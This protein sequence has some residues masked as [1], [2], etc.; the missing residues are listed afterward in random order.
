MI[1][2][3]NIISGMINQNKENDIFYFVQIIK[4]RKDNPDMI[5]GESE[6][7]NFFIS[8]AKDLKGLESEIIKLCDMHN[9]RAYITLNKK[10][11]EKVAK[12]TVRR[13]AET[14]ESGNYNIRGIYNSCCSKQSVKK[15][16]VW[17]LDI[18]GEY[19]FNDIAIDLLKNNSSII[20]SL[21]TKNGIHMIVKPFN[22]DEFVK[23][24]P[25]LIHK[26]ATTLLYIP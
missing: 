10:S 25:D 26:S 5:K 19:S 13:I 24:Y 9:A 14:M 20:E 11:Y 7:K 4:R 17:V 18:D 22:S 16:R 6:I 3:F 2:N 23:K 12:M 21:K 15:D 1:N 8:D